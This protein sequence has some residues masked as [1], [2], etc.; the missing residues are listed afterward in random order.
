MPSLLLATPVADA[1]QFDVSFNGYHMA[2][3]TLDA[4]IPLCGTSF[5]RDNRW[6]SIRKR[7]T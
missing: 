3:V 5:K 1:E 4:R 2:I 6:C 7:G